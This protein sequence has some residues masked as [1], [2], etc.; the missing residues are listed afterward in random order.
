MIYFKKMI[1]N[2]VALV[3]NSKGKEYIVIGKGIAF[4]KKIGDPIERSK[5][6]KNYSLLES[7]NQNLLDYFKD[8][9]YELF[10]TVDRIKTLIEER[11]NLTYTD[12]MY[13]SLVDHI[14]GSITR[15]KL[16]IK[17]ASE[18]SNEELKYY[19]R[20]YQLAQDS[21]KIIK[22][23]LGFEFDENELTFLTLHYIG[24]LYDLKYTQL[25]ERALTISNDIL[26]IITESIGSEKMH[27]FAVERLIIH[28]KFF[29]IRQLNKGDNGDSSK[30]YNHQMY[31]FLTMQNQEAER[32]LLKIIKYLEEN[33]D[34]KVTL[35]EWLY[36]LIHIVKIIK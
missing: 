9:D 15:I 30:D 11:C 18:I 20:E 26:G 17:I 8:F 31:E 33:Y 13:L 4:Q 32:I 10:Q 29:S 3:E 2:N 22:E 14:N 27:G 19:V 7:E 34:F 21:N 16:D 6:E 28:L 23:E 36:L 24:I 25:N 1:N 5:V 35:D 12:H